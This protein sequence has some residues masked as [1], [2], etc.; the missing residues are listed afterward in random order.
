MRAASST[1]ATPE[2][3]S[4][5]PGASAVA[6]I[7]S[8]TRL[9]ICAPTMTTRLG[10]RP[11]WKPSTSTISTPFGARGPVKVRAI[12]ATVM[13]P[14]QASAMRVISPPTQCRAAPMPRTG[15]SGEDRVWR[16]PKLTSFST[17]ALRRAGSGAG[18]VSLAKAGWAIRAIRATGRMVRII[19]SCRQGRARSSPDRRSA[20]GGA[21]FARAFSL[22][23]SSWRARQPGRRSMTFK[24]QMIPLSL[25]ASALPAAAHAAALQ[26]QV[27]AGARAVRSD[28]YA[29][30]RT[31]TVER[32]GAAR[33]VFVEQ[34]DP[35]KPAV[36]QWSLLGVDGHAPTAKDLEQ[37]RRADRGPVPSY[38]QL[39]KWF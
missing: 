25:A 36:Q 30:R 4:L 8:V 35:R 32:T 11:C 27:L 23:Q 19:A 39:A 33:Q 37:W 5:A 26:D 3:S 9:S 14:W 7:T 10:S 29:F 20:R 1:K 24:N 16:V 38:A 13:Q 34:Y 28:L 2:P 17:V 22:P 12:L 18:A 31:R 6:F 21:N 15:S